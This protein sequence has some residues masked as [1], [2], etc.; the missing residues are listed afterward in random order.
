MKKLY[1]YINEIRA[2]QD[3]FTLIELLVVIAII[4]ILAVAVLAAINPIEQINKG[5]DTQA[6]ADASQLVSAVERYFT[7][8]NP[9]A[10]P[11][12]VAVNGY[13]PTAIN[14]EDAFLLDS[15]TA[16]GD[17]TWLD[18]LAATQEVKDT[19]ANRLKNSTK[20]IV[21]KAA[22]ANVP[23]YA[24]YYPTSN[25]GKKNADAYCLTNSA[26]VNGASGMTLCQTA[27]SGVNNPI[28]VP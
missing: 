3:G 22:G 27:G 16:G 23:T 9:P 7:N 1:A 24:C 12:S 25:S 13:T 19:F 17:W 15:V 14:P 20:L 6:N 10:Y 21:F 26:T 5:R 11:W 4:G 28:C 8:S 18:N 2:K